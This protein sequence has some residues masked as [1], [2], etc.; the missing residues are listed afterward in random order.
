MKL[1]IGY[2]ETFWTILAT[3]SVNIKLFENKKL[4]RERQIA[5]VSEFKDKCAQS[6]HVSFFYPSWSCFHSLL[7]CSGTIARNQGG[8]QETG[9]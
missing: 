7:S 9:E 8:R 4:E 3:F 5:V 6:P 1:D 2:M